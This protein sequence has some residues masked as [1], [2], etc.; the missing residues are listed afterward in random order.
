MNDHRFDLLSDVQREYLR[1]VH[2]GL[3]S[4]Q[5]AQQ[6]GGSHH[7]VDAE[8]AVAMKMIGA[9]RRTQAAALFAAHEAS[10]S[11]EPSYEPPSVAVSADPAVIPAP[12]ETSP[13]GGIPLPIPTVGRPINE[14]TFWQRTAWIVILAVGIALAAGGLLSGIIAQLN[15]LGQRT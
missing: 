13:L 11:Y 7:T 14:Q 4:K 15:A 5:I 10:L 1:L 6:R 3:T 2:R 9:E 8:I 12:G